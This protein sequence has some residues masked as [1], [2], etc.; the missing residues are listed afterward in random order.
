MVILSGAQ[1]SRRI[2]RINPWVTLRDSSTSL[3]MTLKAEMGR[4]L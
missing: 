3:G 2:P 4:G 1:Q